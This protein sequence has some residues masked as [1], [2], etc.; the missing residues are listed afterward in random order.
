MLTFDI[1]NEITMSENP[2]RFVFNN[3]IVLFVENIYIMVYRCI[4]YNIPKKIHPW[5][6]WDNSYKLTEKCCND[7]NEHLSVNRKLYSISKYRTK[8]MKESFIELYTTDNVDADFFDHDNTGICLLKYEDDKFKVVHN[9]TNI[10][11]QNMNQDA[12][13]YNIDGKLFLTYNGFFIENEKKI[14]KMM[15]VEINVNLEKN[16]MFINSE[17]SLLNDYKLVEKNCII[18]QTDVLYSINKQFIIERNSIKITYFS[19]ILSELYEKFPG[20]YFSLGTQTIPFNKNYLTVGHVKFPITNSYIKDFIKDNNMESIKFLYYKYMYF[21]FFFEFTKDYEIVNFSDLFIMNNSSS[22]IFPTGLTYSHDERI[23]LSYGEND[24]KCMI[25]SIKKEDIEYCFNNSSYSHRLFNN[26]YFLPKVLHDYKYFNDDISMLVFKYLSKF[27]GKYIPLFDRESLHKSITFNEDI[28]INFLMYNFYTPKVTITNDKFKIGIN[29][30]NNFCNKESISYYIN[31]IYEFSEFCKMILLN[32]NFEIY[33]IPFLINN[34][35]DNEDKDDNDINDH[36]KSLCYKVNV[37]NIDKKT[38]YVEDIL[39]TVNSMN[40]MICT[41]KNSE[42]FSLIT[43]TPFV[44]INFCDSNV[45]ENIERYNTDFSGLDFFK[46]IH[47]KI[48][49]MVELNK[50]REKMEKERNNIILKLPEII[51]RWNTLIDIHL[52][53]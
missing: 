36:I 10:F 23:L 18:H 31:L 42:I 35:E 11:G 51:E 45:C 13:I 8:K 28:D 21:F 17:K 46:W 26:K 16:F 25:S 27:N 34:N 5:K 19:K 15:K 40:F 2:N 52:M 24:E 43:N 9:I 29:L 3:S 47:S 50:I 22:V 53:K 6:Y 39:D 48:G 44:S 49:K 32:P 14:V 37:I 20:I 12:R 38:N 33:L 7:E 30:S 1:T 41:S 4:N